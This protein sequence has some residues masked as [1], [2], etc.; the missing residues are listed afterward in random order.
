[1]SHLSS[2]NTEVSPNS[3]EAS[4]A[5]SSEINAPSAASSSPDDSH[6]NQSA[7]TKELEL[8]HTRVLYVETLQPLADV[9]FEQQRDIEEGREKIDY[10]LKQME[11]VLKEKAKLYRQITEVRNAIKDQKKL[12]MQMTRQE[13]EAR[14]KRC[15]E[16]MEKIEVMNNAAKSTF[17]ANVKIC[18]TVLKEAVALEDENNNLS[19][20]LYNSVS[21]A[22]KAKIAGLNDRIE[23]FRKLKEDEFEDKLED[24][25]EQIRELTIKVEEK[26]RKEME[27]EEERKRRLKEIAGSSRAP[28]KK[29]RTRSR[30]PKRGGK[31]I[32]SSAINSSLNI[33]SNTNA[34]MSLSISTS[35]K[36]IAKRSSST[37]RKGSS[38]K[39][40]SINKDE[41][42]IYVKRTASPQASRTTRTLSTSGTIDSDTNTSSNLNR[43][44]APDLPDEVISPRSQ[45]P[46]QFDENYDGIKRLPKSRPESPHSPR[47]TQVGLESPKGSIILFKKK[48]QKKL[49]P[50]EPEEDK[51]PASTK[52]RKINKTRRG[53]KSPPRKRKNTEPSARDLARKALYS[54]NS[55]SSGFS[56]AL[57]KYNES[58]TFSF[59]ND[60]F[61][62]YQ[63]PSN[64]RRNKAKDSD[65]LN[66]SNISENRLDD[67]KRLE[68][69]IEDNSSNSSNCQLRFERVTK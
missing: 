9:M 20:L 23:C 39:S 33:T 8:P 34:S 29:S 48:P 66:L 6:L 58:S 11:F 16:M 13:V 62:P 56:N 31:K 36:A 14:F 37:N 21:D 53:R 44:P 49:P 27:E 15:D 55:V 57:G 3:Y 52:R 7:I 60:D 4:F 65:S 22:A 51:K 10:L 59:S 28:S 25:D 26:E 46:F 42:V 69:K 18:K 50:P 12:A 43:K 41:D 61:N 1:M 45:G 24:M 67:M 2:E 19:H 17:D 63:P 68:S 32:N 54:D 38:K 47:S 35:S 40:S 64:S 5:S 30:S